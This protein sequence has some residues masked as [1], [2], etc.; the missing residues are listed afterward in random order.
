MTNFSS[1]GL[2]LAGLLSARLCHDLA[3][4]V[5]AANNGAELLSE[6][7]AEG[8]EAARELIS[9]CAGQAV[10]RLR[11]FRL[12]YGSHHGSMDWSGAMQT[13][14]AMLADSK[15]EFA[16]QGAYDG[17]EDQEIAGAGKLAL[18]MMLLAANALPRGGRLDFAA[19]GEACGPRITIRGSGGYAVGH[20]GQIVVAAV[21]DTDFAALNRSGRGAGGRKCAGLRNLRRFGNLNG[22]IAVRDGDRIDAY[23]FAH[24]DDSGGLVDDHPRWHI[25]I[26]HEL[27][28]VGEQI[29]NSAAI[30]VGN[31]ERYGPRIDQ[32][33]EVAAEKGIDRNGD[34]SGCGEVWIAQRYVDVLH[35]C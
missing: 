17:A 5:G 3:G 15:I 4:P 32:G 34:A 26:D 6:G 23:I 33:G 28:D 18:N 24:D 29:G 19:A 12:A 30:G 22:Q 10:R 7:G 25:R 8:M 1:L 13:G 27:F 35:C 21:I 11:F 20:H 14:A 31:A 2:E 9:N 16:W